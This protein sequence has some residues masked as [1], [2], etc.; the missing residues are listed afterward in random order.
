MKHK[1]IKMQGK[2]MT[3]FNNARKAQSLP[4]IT[5]HRNFAEIGQYPKKEFQWHSGNN[6]FL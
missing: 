5:I 1:V 4:P 2:L 3:Q 6:R